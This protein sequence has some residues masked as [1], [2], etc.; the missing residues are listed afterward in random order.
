MYNCFVT[1][2]FTLAVTVISITV[3]FAQVNDSVKNETLKKQ[4][5]SLINDAESY[6]EYRVIKTEQLNAFQKVIV[7][8][9]KSFNKVKNEAV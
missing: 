3:S 5:N 4:F 2:L 8:S 7:D 6:N 9:V 1:R